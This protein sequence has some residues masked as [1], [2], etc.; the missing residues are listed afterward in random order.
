MGSSGLC[1]CGH[2]RW[3][4]RRRLGRTR[5]GLTRGQ[6]QK[7]KQEIL[8]AMTCNHKVDIKAQSINDSLVAQHENKETRS[9]ELTGVGA[10]VGLAVGA[11]GSTTQ[12]TPAPNSHII[13]GQHSAGR[14]AP[15][16]PQAWALSPSAAQIVPS[17]VVE[18]KVTFVASVQYRDWG[19]G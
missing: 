13:P 8:E 2:R 14:L 5:S 6:L 16:A 4:Q 3:G 18:A 10:L 7:K 9:Y 17:P 19:P 1:S 12:R 11:K 15:V